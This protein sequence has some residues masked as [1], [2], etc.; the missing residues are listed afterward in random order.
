MWMALLSKR[1]PK[2]EATIYTARIDQGLR[3]DLKR[4]NAQYPA[5]KLKSF[6][7]AHDRFLIIDQKTVCHIGA[8]LKDLG[9]RPVVSLSY[10]GLPFHK[11]TW[12]PPKCSN[13][14]IS[15]VLQGLVPIKE[16][17]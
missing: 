14:S 17:R 6:D 7:K 15:P 1:Q 10:H 9:K 8:S 11:S 13:A 5:I 2:V 3:N 4:H 12:M 16:P